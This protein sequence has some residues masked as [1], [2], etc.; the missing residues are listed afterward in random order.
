MKC[1]IGPV[2]CDGCLPAEWKCVCIFVVFRLPSGRLPFSVTKALEMI[3][4]QCQVWS[5]MCTNSSSFNKANCKTYLDKTERQGFH[6]NCENCWFS[7]ENHQF[8]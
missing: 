3:T 6:E 8:S 7:Y 5:P 4:K 1:A 2:G